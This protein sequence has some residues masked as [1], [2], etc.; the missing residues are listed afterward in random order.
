MNKI[1]ISQTA[2]IWASK[3]INRVES[4]KGIVPEKHK[5]ASFLELYYNQFGTLSSITYSPNYK[6]FGI[7]YLE[8]S[9]YLYY[10]FFP[11][12]DIVVD[13]TQ[14]DTD[15]IGVDLKNYYTKTQT[16]EKI[17]EE[18]NKLNLEG[19]ASK[20]YVDNEIKTI[21]LT[22]GPIGP[23]GPKGEQ[24]IQGIPG[25]KG[26]TGER[27]LQGEQGIPGVPGIN[28]AQGPKGD[29]G[30]QGERGLQGPQGIP[31]VNGN[32][33]ADGA[34]GPIGPKGEQGERGLKGDKGDPGERGP[35]GPMGPQ[36]P[37]GE[38]ADIDLSNYVTTT[39]FTSEIN[40]INTTLGDV[41]VILDSILGTVPTVINEILE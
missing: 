32:D 1:N 18:V 33:G 41:N 8:G 7:K 37:A 40:K 4:D 10:G 17:I 34:E 25:D 13:S 28:G 29:K 14:I 5:L 24:G 19:F 11:E 21:E 26:D 38:G 31:G 2:A 27:G 6:I 36:G 15:N 3:H 20:E 12:Y 35:E 30:E 23:Q 22:P 39:L 16:D 9:K